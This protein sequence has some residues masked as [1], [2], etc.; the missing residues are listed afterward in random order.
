MC[1][2]DDE[3]RL[4]TTVNMLNALFSLEKSSTSDDGHYNWYERLY[5]FE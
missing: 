3:S 4:L 2:Q 1:W 5:V